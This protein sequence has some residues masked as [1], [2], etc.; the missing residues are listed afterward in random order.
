VTTNRKAHAVSVAPDAAGSGRA[1]GWC[2]E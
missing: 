1:I 2:H